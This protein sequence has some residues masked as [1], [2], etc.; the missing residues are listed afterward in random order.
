MDTKQQER[1]E[2]DAKLRERAERDV[3]ALIAKLE[4]K[5]EAA[6]ARGILADRY[7][8]AREV[9]ALISSDSKDGLLDEMTLEAWVRRAP[10]RRP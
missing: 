8:T 6:M 5:I 9:R 4:A 7:L 10:S 3:R 1:A 2:L